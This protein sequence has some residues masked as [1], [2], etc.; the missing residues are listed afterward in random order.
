[1]LG[2][3]DKARFARDGFVILRGAI[4]PEQVRAAR[5]VIAASLEKDESH[6]RMLEQLQS[7]FCADSVA[8]PDIVGLLEPLRPAIAELFGTAEAP[9]ADGAQIALRFPQLRSIG[10][11]RHGFHLDGYPAGANGIPA[12][13]IF[14]NTLLAGVYLTPLRGPDRGNFVVWPG[15]HRL[16]ARHLRDLDAP[17]HLREHGAEPLLAKIR[18]LECG[19]PLQVE[20]EAGDAVLAHHLLG[21][22][23]A[24]NFSLRTRETVYFRLL[25]PADR[26]DD[27]EPLM[28]ET[29]F[30]AGVDW[31]S[32]GS[33]EA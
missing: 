30:F 25:H 14:R 9:V 24:D 13:T 15:S 18:A 23:A 20:V 8:H 2:D 12:G 27:P 21:H 26:L 16:F 7:T 5:A 29:R 1:V 33:T 22:G 19:P 10:D 28:D 3:G 11:E 4:P 31:S 17:R 32:A 6:G